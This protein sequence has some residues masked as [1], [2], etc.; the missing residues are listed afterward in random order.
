M[1]QLLS[2]SSDRW[3]NARVA[4][5]VVVSLLVVAGVAFKCATTSFTHDESLSY[6]NYVHQSF[7]EIVSY[8]TPYTNNH[9]LNTLLMK[10]GEAVFGTREWALRLHSVLAGAGYLFFSFRITRNLPVKFQL[11]G[12]VLLLANPYLLDFFGLARGYGLSI[13][14][15]MMAVYYMLLALKNTG[16]GNLVL[17]NIAA[18]LAACSNFSLINF[19]VAALSAYYF[20]RMIDIRRET[21]KKRRHRQM[22]IRGI[23]N[24]LFVLAT[25]LILWEP[26][27]KI[28]EMGVLD[29]GGRN[30]F[31]KDTVSSVIQAGFYDIPVVEGW[32]YGIAWLAA[33]CVIASCAY[34]IAEV[35]KDRRS[36][37][38]LK[39]LIFVNVTLGLIVLA[40]IAQHFL[41]KNDYFVGRF[42]LF[43]FPLFIL[44]LLL[45]WKEL[46]EQGIFKN[47]LVNFCAGF[48]TLALLNTAYNAN[49]HFYL[50]WSYDKD[51]KRVVELLRTHHA[52]H[53]SQKPVSLGDYWH[54]EPTL[55][56]YRRLW[57]LDWLQPVT[58]E[59]PKE[60][61][62]Y[63]Y[64]I[65]KEMLGVYSGAQDTLF[66]SIY[67]P[68]TFCLVYN[69]PSHKL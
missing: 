57:K 68:H 30:G 6:N 8:A 28:R 29:F 38:R 16:Y 15:M 19:Y 18:L 50:D 40:T 41:L 46:H 49:H 5:A 39:A 36:V 67:G 64:S 58:R 66:R 25:T 32:V 7:M 47:V 51:T 3:R 11:G 62:A 12:F 33:A 9:I 53:A 23:I 55:N 21:D 45:W 10:L 20:I 31:V 27:R 13:C 26:I 60:T 17:F 52:Q 44:N 63:F 2:H 54:F 61:D 56:F 22:L 65:Q 4:A 42:A 14:F 35:A 34:W 59:D 48:A 24:F 69:H 43:L 37:V 1:K